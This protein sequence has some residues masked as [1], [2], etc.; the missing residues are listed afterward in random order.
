M[1]DQ[2]KEFLSK[3]ISI[4]FPEEREE[5]EE[6]ADGFIQLFLRE[7]ACEEAYGGVHNEFAA[8]EQQTD[9]SFIS[10]IIGTM[11]TLA[12]IQIKAG[13]ANLV[14]HALKNWEDELVAAGLSTTIARKISTAYSDDFLNCL[15]HDK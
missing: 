3:I 15:S 11:K 14:Q 10:L 8:I 6:Y 1:H 5:F 2:A 13:D 4:E 12:A 9:S 7:D